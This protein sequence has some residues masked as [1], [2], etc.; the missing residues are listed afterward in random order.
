LAS[1]LENV[2][3]KSFKELAQEADAAGGPTAIVA[4][5]SDDAGT[6]G[7]RLVYLARYDGDNEDGDNDPFSGADQGL[8]WV[9]VQ[10]ED[11]SAVV[12]TLTRR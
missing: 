5:Y 12:H 8:L 10:V 2:L 6:Q 9:R 4:V 11:S 1:K 7:R 3:A